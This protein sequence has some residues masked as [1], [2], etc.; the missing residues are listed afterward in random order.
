MPVKITQ[1]CTLTTAWRW[2]AVRATMTT[3]ASAAIVGHKW[4]KQ[5]SV[6]HMTV[7]W[8]HSDCHVTSMWLNKTVYSYF[9]VCSG[10]MDIQMSGKTT[11]YLT[12]HG[13]HIDQNYGSPTLYRFKLTI[14]NHRNLSSSDTVTVIY[15][16]GWYSSLQ[17][18][19]DL[20][21]F[22]CGSCLTLWQLCVNCLIEATSCWSVIF[23][24][25]PTLYC[26]MKLSHFVT[27][28][29][30]LGKLLSNRITLGKLL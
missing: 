22:R 2:M 4:G 24:E 18:A 19:F 27:N 6:D 26:T 25:T 16:K 10:P 29:E 15:R 17:V 13:L 3:T 21:C 14:T 30:T 5:H 1:W 28:S 8:P 9:N 11:A 23:W 20:L 7:M 12:L